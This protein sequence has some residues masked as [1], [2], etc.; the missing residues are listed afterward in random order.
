MYFVIF[1]R[2]GFISGLDLP[3]S[4]EKALLSNL[5]TVN[6]PPIILSIS[7]LEK[8]PAAFIFYLLIFF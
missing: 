3:I 7:L 8:P 4:L 5:G 6:L 1:C 2:Y